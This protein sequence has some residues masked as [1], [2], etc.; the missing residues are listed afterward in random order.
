MNKKLISQVYLKG[1]SL[2]YTETTKKD[3]FDFIEKNSS[4]K[5]PHKEKVYSYIHSITPSCRICD[6]IPKFENFKVGYKQYCSVS[7]SVKDNKELQEKTRKENIN[8]LFDMPLSKIFSS[9][10]SGTLKVQ[11]WRDIAKLSE[12][13]KFSTLKQAHFHFLY[14]NQICK[15]GWILSMLGDE[16][17]KCHVCTREKVVSDRGK[18]GKPQNK[19]G[20][21]KKEWL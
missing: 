21:K 12:Y 5:I 4:L 10:E 18:H 11:K 14:K 2:R 8:I 9:L 16:N 19:T 20:F 15:C 3:V 13:T 6:N 17:R 1:K 7:C